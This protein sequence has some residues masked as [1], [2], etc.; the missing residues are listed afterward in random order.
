MA[1]RQWTQAQRE[2]QAKLIHRWKPW[3]KSTSARTPEGKAIS[4][5]NAYRYALREV[6]REMT[7]VNREMLNYLNGWSPPPDWREAFAKS[8]ELFAE[9]ECAQKVSQDAKVQGK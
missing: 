1:A 4:S 5:K 7:R 9:L 8:N 3:E 2:R 6:Y